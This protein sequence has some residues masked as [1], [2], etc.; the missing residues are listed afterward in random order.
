MREGRAGMFTRYGRTGLILFGIA[1]YGGP[2]LAG[3]AGHGWKVLPVF[4]ALFLLHVSATRRPDM[5]TAAGWAGF[6]MMAAVQ[7]LLVA[8]AWGL[9]LGLADIAAPVALPI[10]APIALTAVA[11]GFGAWA[12]RDA[13]EM[14]VMLDSAIRAI[15]TLEPDA[16]PTSGLDWPEPDPSVRAAL[17]TALEA[18]HGLDKLN[19]ALVDPVVRQLE[20]DAGAAAFDP[21][22]DLAGQ[23]GEDND[24]IVDYA[25]LRYVASP[26]VLI[27]LIGRGEGGLAPQLLL[28]APDPDVRFE[29]RGRVADLL[30]AGASDDQLPDAD[31]LALLARRFPGE[32]YEMLAANCRRG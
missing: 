13:A 6:A 9:G 16:A 4:A 12:W 32:G 2:F 3:L 11:A 27:A 7:I 18:L 5:T 25:L 30:D 20:T 19:P 1:L 17:E 29:A 15:E 26:P 8:L 14:D 24:P 22:Y 28:D 10:W 21:F 23:D 31:R